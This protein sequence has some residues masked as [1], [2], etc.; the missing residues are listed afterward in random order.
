MYASRKLTKV[1]HLTRHY[2]VWAVGSEAAIAEAN[3]LVAHCGE[4]MGAATQHGRALP[5]WLRTLVGEKWSREQLTQWQEEMRGLAASRKRFGEIA[6]KELGV[7]A[8]NLFVSQELGVPGTDKPSATASHS[9][10]D[11]S[12]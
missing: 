8:V 3:D 1:H 12:S 11:K 4:V 6:R 9:A 10:D 7:E 2:Q 5:A